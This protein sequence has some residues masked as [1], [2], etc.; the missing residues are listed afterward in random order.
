[1]FFNTNLKYL[2]NRFGVIAGP[3]QFGKQDQG[4]VS[5]WIA[6]HI[7]K[8]KLSY[9]GFGGKGYQVRDVIHIQDVCQI[10]YLQIKK[11]KKINNKTFNIGGGSKNAIYLR[12]LTNRCQDLTKNKIKIKS[13]LKT[14]SY[15]VPY[16]V[17]DN[18]KVFKFYKWKPNKNLNTVIYDTYKWLKNFN[19]LINIF[20]ENRFNNWF[21][22]LVGSEA[23]IFFLKRF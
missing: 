6:K 1:M 8:K 15:D 13:V 10:I 7:L 18:S 3:W 12:N 4:F 9:I 11:L 20:N 21:M 2:I 23:T 22:W 5:L 17:S 19:K 16:Y 14:S